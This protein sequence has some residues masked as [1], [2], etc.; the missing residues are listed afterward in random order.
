[1]FS[2]QCETEED[3][4]YSP[5]VNLLQWC[6]GANKNVGMQKVLEWNNMR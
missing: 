2:G 1:M 6:F 3:D 5:S 4:D